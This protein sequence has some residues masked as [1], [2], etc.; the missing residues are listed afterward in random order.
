MTAWTQQTVAAHLNWTKLHQQNPKITQRLLYFSDM[1]KLHETILAD[2]KCETD[3]IE[4]IL[5][6]TRSLDAQQA[7][8]QH[9][10]L[11]EQT[12]TNLL[13][14]Y[15]KNL[16][17]LA[18]DA[19]GERTDLTDTHLKLFK[20][21]PETTL[22]KNLRNLRNKP[23]NSLQIYWI[24]KR[25]SESQKIAV[26]QNKHISTEKIFAGIHKH[27]LKTKL[28]YNITAAILQKENLPADIIEHIVEGHGL[29][30]ILNEV[31]RLS[32]Y[33]IEQPNCPNELLEQFTKSAYVEIREQAQAKLQNKSYKNP[34]QKQHENTDPISLTGSATT[35]IKN[36]YVYGLNLIKTYQQN[37]DIGELLEQTNIFL[38][39]PAGTED[40]TTLTLL[41]LIA[42]NYSDTTFE[43]SIKSQKILDAIQKQY[44]KIPTESIGVDPAGTPIP[45]WMTEY[46]KQALETIAQK[47][48]DQIIQN[49]NTLAKT[50]AQKILAQKLDVDL[51]KPQLATASRSRSAKSPDVKI[52]KTK[53]TGI[54][55]EL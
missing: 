36:I 5:K 2:P 35:Y 42:Y 54:N 34:L 20:N 41:A 44:Q 16:D 15:P 39:P 12:I 50:T 37:T 46:E 38:N 13:Q 4:L 27:L 6:N 32:K 33:A 51:Q 47:L 53:P 8:A 40:V 19:L 21:I 28:E 23:L 31:P 48:Y 1:Y 11:D 3:T 17:L 24:F 25:G 14:N 7:A 55:I 10:N 52:R 30:Y 29:N 22:D 43:N 18:A 49:R 45:A 26:L 9:P